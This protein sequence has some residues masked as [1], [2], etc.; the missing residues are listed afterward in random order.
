MIKKPAKLVE[1]MPIGRN[2]GHE[3]RAR[4]VSVKGDSLTVRLFAVKGTKKKRKIALMD[5]CEV[6]LWQNK[7][8]QNLGR[9]SIVMNGDLVTGVKL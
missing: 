5:R 7:T 2:S 3:I 8:S 9:F 1:F 4:S 6:L